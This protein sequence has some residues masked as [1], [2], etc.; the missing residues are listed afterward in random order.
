VYH[1]QSS[2]V[3]AERLAPVALLPLSD[4]QQVAVSTVLHVIH[5]QPAEAAEAAAQQRPEA[6]QMVV[7]TAAMAL[8][9]PR[10]AVMDKAQQ[11]ENFTKRLV[12]YMLVAAELLA[13]QAAC[14]A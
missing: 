9:R 3:L 13:E 8:A 1:T 12:L 14:M 10:L 7:Q 6:R 5:M 2:W 4:T 11:R